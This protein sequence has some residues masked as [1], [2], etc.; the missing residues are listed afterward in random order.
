MPD[1]EV[2]EAAAL[3]PS[4]RAPLD[5]APFPIADVAEPLLDDAPESSRRPVAFGEPADPELS[6]GPPESGEIESQP[7]PR[8]T[9]ESAAAAATDDDDDDGGPATMHRMAFGDADAPTPKPYSQA[10]AVDQVVVVDR[11]LEVQSPDLVV[12]VPRSQ[13]RSTTFG[14]ILDRA[15]SLLA[16]PTE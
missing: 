8:G 16:P 6:I 2:L 9:A 7:Y 12:V 15:L 4:T 3:G 11:S 14:A 10:A 13:P 5:S 1:V